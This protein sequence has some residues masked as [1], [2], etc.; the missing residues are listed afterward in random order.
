MLRAFQVGLSGQR[1]RLVDAIRATDGV[2]S[3]SQQ[4][5]LWAGENALLWDSVKATILDL[6]SERATVAAI[7]AGGVD[8]WQ[9]VNDRVIQDAERY[10]LSPA[11]GDFGSIPN[12]NA[13]SKTMFG[14]AFNRWQ[15]GEVPASGPG[16]LDDL[17]RL[18]QPT[19]GASRATTIAATETSRIFAMSEIAAGNANEFIVGWVY[20]TANDSLVSDLCRPANGTV[21]MKGQSTFPDGLGPPPRHVNCR[22]SIQSITGPAL[23]ALREQGAIRG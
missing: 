4:N 15:R 23:D 13:T 9:Q 2:L 19:F 20:N 14:D 16:G 12:L 18:L 11:T 1:D 21:M 5:K 8:I 7:H 17:I 10:Y 3:A 6:A 22:S